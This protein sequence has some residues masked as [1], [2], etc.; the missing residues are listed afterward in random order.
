[1][2]PAYLKFQ[3]WFSPGEAITQAISPVLYYEE[4][5]KLSTALTMY[6]QHDWIRI[7]AAGDYVAVT[8]GLFE[9][10]SKHYAIR[11]REYR[12]RAGD[13]ELLDSTADLTQEVFLKLSEKNRWQHYLD[14]GYDSAAVEHEI[15][16]IEIAN[17]VGQTLRNRYP[18][19]FRL[20]RRIT[21]VLKTDP[22]FK[23]FSASDKTTEVATRACRNQIYG[24]REWPINKPRKDDSLFPDLAK[25]VA[26]RTRNTRRSGRGSSSHVIISNQELASLIAEILEAADSPIELRVIRQL[27]LPKLTLTDVRVTSLSSVLADQDSP[28]TFTELDVVDPHPTPEQQLCNKELIHQMELQVS[29]LLNSLQAAVNHK[30]RRWDRLLRVAWDC[31]F[32]SHT[33]SQSRIAAKLGISNAL[34]THYRTL[35]D[36]HVKTLALPFEHWLILNETLRARLVGLISALDSPVDIQLAASPLPISRDAQ[37]AAKKTA[38]TSVMMPQVVNSAPPVTLTPNRPARAASANEVRRERFAVGSAA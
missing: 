12:H 9:L 17:I 20:V 35:F 28:G 29:D 26:C 1:L 25:T 18:E 22:R 8:Q 31:Y 13:T 15:C 37:R 30:S 19:S 6:I 7:I 14:A 36:Q 16:H 3:E 24:L 4:A 2:R 27:V 11:N 5:S 32:D 34:V 10:V 33:W 38:V 21:A 23:S